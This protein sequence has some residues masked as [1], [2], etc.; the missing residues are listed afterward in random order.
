M[1]GGGATGAPSS[2]DHSDIA[3][4]CVRVVRSLTSE[5]PPGLRGVA[6]VVFLFFQ[7]GSSAAALFPWT[8]SDTRGG[9]SV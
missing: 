9:L 4:L 1:L 2:S 8:F 3:A 6:P 7:A 5:M